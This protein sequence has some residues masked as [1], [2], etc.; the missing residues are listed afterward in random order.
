VEPVLRLGIYPE[1]EQPAILNRSIPST[2]GAT[3]SNP[4]LLQVRPSSAFQRLVRLSM[5]N[6]IYISR[7]KY[8]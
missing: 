4:A 3:M 8:T 2:A 7:E 1:M 5:G 6:T